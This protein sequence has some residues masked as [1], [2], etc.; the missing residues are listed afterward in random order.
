MIP[1]FIRRAAEIEL[2]LIV[3]WAYIH[4]KSTQNVIDF[5]K[6]TARILNIPDF[7]LIES[8][9]LSYKQLMPTPNELVALSDL[10]KSRSKFINSRISH[11]KMSRKTF[12]KTLNMTLPVEKA[13]VNKTKIIVNDAIIKFINAFEKLMQDYASISLNCY[14]LEE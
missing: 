7:G 1:T 10:A 2:A 13:L 6:S 3:D 4:N 11:N 12:Y 8:A 9:I 5:F 14:D